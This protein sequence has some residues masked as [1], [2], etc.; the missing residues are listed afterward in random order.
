MA[1]PRAALRGNGGLVANL[2]N[3][4][5]FVSTARALLHGD[6]CHWNP[7]ARSLIGYDKEND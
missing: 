7:I 2:T 4:P 3:I 6:R 5:G 1:A